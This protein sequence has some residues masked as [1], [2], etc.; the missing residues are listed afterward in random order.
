MTSPT[1]GGPRVSAHAIAAA[2]GQFPPT[3]EQAEVIESPLRPALVVAGAGS[4]KTETMASRVVWLVA[5]GLVRRD[6]VL[7]L[8]FTRKAAGELGERIRRRLERLSEFEERGLLA[9]LGAL[10]AEGALEEFARIERRAEQERDAASRAGRDTAPIELRARAARTAALDRLAPVAVGAEGGDLLQRPAVATYNSF[11]D[12]IVRENAVLLGRDADAAV[13]SESAAWLLMRRVVLSSDDERL[14][15]RTEAMSTIID[16]ALRV[17]RD[18]VDNLV[19]TD[20]LRTMAAEFADVL[21]R[22]SEKRL[23]DGVYRD[24][25]VAA[26]KVSGL[27]V[28]ADLADAYAAEKARRGVLDFSDQVAGALRIVRAHAAVGHE[29]RRRYRVVLLDEYQDTSVVQTL[30]LSELFG[31]EAV[32]AVGDPHQSIYGWRGASAGNLG[33]FARAFGRGGAT[34][35]HA[36]MTSWRNSDVVLRAANAV[37]APLAA[38]SPVPVRPLRPRPGVTAGRLEVAFENDVDAEADAVAAW[39]EAVRAERTAQG[40]STRGAILFRGKKH[41][42]RFADALAA[43]GIPRHILGLGGLLSTPEVVDVVSVLRVVD[44]PTAGSALIRVLSGPRFAVGLADLRLLEKLARRLASHD[45]TLA[46]LEPAVADAV[47]TGAGADQ[48]GSIIEALDFVGRA[49]DDHGWLREFSPA[50]R[51]RLREAAAMFRGLRQAAALPIPELVRLIELELRLDIELAANEA[52]GPARIASAQLR[53]FTDEVHAFLAADDRGTVRS[54]IAWLDHAEQLDEFAP[55]TE[56][57]EDDVVQLLTIHGSKGLEWDAV[58][59]ARVVEGELPV[60]PRDTKAWLG[61]GVLP[62]DFRGDAEWLPRLAWRAHDAPTQQALNAAIAEFVEAGKTRQRDEER[63]LAYVAITRAREHLLLSGSSWAGGQ[64]PREP[65][66]YLAEIAAALGVDHV[67]PEPGEN[68]FEGDRRII[69]WPMDPL[70]EAPRTRRPRVEA[71]AAAVAAAAE[72]PPIEAS[73]DL[74]LLLAERRSRGGEAPEPPVRVPASRFKDWVGDYEG[75]LRRIARP[76]PERPYRQTRIG[77]L[78]HAWVEQRSGAGGRGPSLDDALWEHDDDAA[79]ASSASDDDAARLEALKRVF[80]ASEWGPL[81]PVEVETEIDFVLRGTRGASHVVICKLDAV[82]R[83][84]GRYEIVDWKTGRPPASD[85]EREERMLQLALYRL[86]YHRARGVPLEEIDVALYYVADDLVIRGEGSY[87]EED[88][89]QR[90]N[91]AR[92]AR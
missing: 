68:P 63:R 80:E 19:E 27:A 32:M 77:T 46:P 30:L 31:G 91:A 76:M 87:S 81:A 49:R 83:R 39:F 79:E 75:T 73:R 42:Q 72:R 74:A 15:H 61:F 92:E 45:H 90:W 54:L 82:Y 52:H 58:A 12:Q 35:E 47:R 1:Q 55:R 18:A 22:P 88:L 86:A 44:D 4:G 59:V 41:M 26:E 71:A 34:G 85:A 67:R 57:P 9:R 33:G 5:N 17:A 51:E 69:T 64:K 38:S 56:P 14:E 21:D 28:L 13:L 78:F 23:P 7:G 24:V 29:L 43:R 36:L 70:G 3:G 65:A 37:L 16:G 50:A 6:E 20:R 40:R 62:Y 2:L 60:A 25:R 84:D 66:P 11:A 48:P 53:A 8:T 10:H 89:A